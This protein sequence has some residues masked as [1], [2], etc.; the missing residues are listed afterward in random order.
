MNAAFRLGRESS[1]ATVDERLGFLVPIESLHEY[2][3]RPP[4][5]SPF[6]TFIAIL[7]EHPIREQR[8]HGLSFHLRQNGNHGVQTK[9]YERHIAQSAGRVDPGVHAVFWLDSF[10][11][12]GK[13]CGLFPAATWLRVSDHCRSYSCF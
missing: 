5:V 1:R 9:R 4:W 8:A 13:D 12:Q 2:T 10:V 11:L 6:G 7:R 3:A